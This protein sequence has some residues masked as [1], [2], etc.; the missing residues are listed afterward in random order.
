MEYWFRYWLFCWVL[1]DWGWDC[2]YSGLTLIKEI[3]VDWHRSSISMSVKE[4]WILWYFYFDRF[5]LYRSSLS[6]FD[7]LFILLC[8]FEDRVLEESDNKFFGMLVFDKPKNLVLSVFVGCL[9]LGSRIV[10]CEVNILF[11]LFDNDWFDGFFILL[12]GWK[13]FSGRC[14]NLL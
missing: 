4:C 14:W 11:L 2:R 8:F 7:G 13:R 12:A 5:F 9:L 1:V 3:L 10:D 6:T